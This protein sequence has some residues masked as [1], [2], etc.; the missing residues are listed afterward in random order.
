VEDGVLWGADGQALPV[1]YAAHP[2]YRDG[3]IVDA[4]V[5]FLDVA[6]QRAAE[7]ARGRAL[8]EAERLVRVRSE[9]LANMSHEIRTPLNAVLGLAR[10]G[11]RKSAESTA[12]EHF[13]R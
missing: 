4:V 1:Q 7:A 3:R 12:R 10:I 2:M 5:S 13:R 9:F 8:A 6:A 11:R